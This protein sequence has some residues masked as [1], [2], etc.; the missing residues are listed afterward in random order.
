M[1]TQP[2]ATPLDAVAAQAAS[3]A[4]GLDVAFLGNFLDVVTDAVDAGV[5]LTRKQLRE[6][7][8]HGDEA[9]RISSPAA[10]IDAA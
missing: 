9:A 2:D 4:G 10:A 5:P 1:A 3:D 8:V 7:R 6:C